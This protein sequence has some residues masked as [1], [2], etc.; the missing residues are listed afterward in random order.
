MMGH[1]S[2]RDAAFLP[3]QRSRR[4]S[5]R[6]VRAPR[7]RARDAAPSSAEHTRRPPTRPISARQ[8]NAPQIT[9]WAV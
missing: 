5:T 1:E 8:N 3:E 2:N 9:H 7:A 6:R 4:T